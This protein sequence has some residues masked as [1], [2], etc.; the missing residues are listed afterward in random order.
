MFSAAGLHLLTSDL[1]SLCLTFPMCDLVMKIY[2][3]FFQ[4]VDVM[5]LCFVPRS[6]ADVKR[7]LMSASCPLVVHSHA[8]WC[9]D[10]PFFWGF[11]ALGLAGTVNPR[12]RGQTQTMGL[13]ELRSLLQGG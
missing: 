10:W 4:D 3:S 5:I 11:V 2:T 6:A 12:R 8:Q 13:G 1:S 9:G 7:V